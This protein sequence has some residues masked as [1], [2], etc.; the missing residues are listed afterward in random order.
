MRLMRGSD[1]APD[2]YL[3]WGACLFICYLDESGVAAINPQSS[4]FVLL[5]LAI[6]VDSW[7]KKDEQVTAVKGK[8]GLQDAEIHTA[9]MTRDYPEQATIPGLETLDW[10]QRRNAV[11]GIRSLNLGRRTGKKLA[12]LTKTYK[13][14]ESYIHLTLSERKY[15]LL[16]LANLLR[17]W[18]DIRIFAEARDKTHA[19]DTKERVFDLAFEQVVTRL[20]F[21]LTNFD[22]RGLLVQDNNQDVARRLTEAMRRYHRK[23]TI[24]KMVQRIIET[25]MFVDSSLTSMVQMADLCAYATRRFFECNERT[26]FGPIFRRFDRNKGKLVGLRHYTGGFKCT[27]HVCKEHGRYQLRSRARSLN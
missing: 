20:D 22:C 16:E 6:P 26:L 27:C 4:H 10:D 23:G 18:A 11:L 7:K 15:C 2:A 8:Y 13:K 12:E 19:P 3:L 5:A 21:C 14:T 25:P 24:W 17:S 9:W 1:P